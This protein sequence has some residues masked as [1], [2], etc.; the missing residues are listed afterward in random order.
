MVQAYFSYDEVAPIYQIT[1]KMDRFVYKNLL[2]NVM[3]PYAEENMPL[4]WVF[5]HDNGPKY[6]SKFVKEWL[7]QSKVSILE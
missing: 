3:L 5:Q 1:E 2:V 4:V 7:S 6:A